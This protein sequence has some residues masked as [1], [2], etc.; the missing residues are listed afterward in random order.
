MERARGIRMI[1]YSIDKW[2]LGKFCG[3]WPK[4]S[5]FRILAKNQS[6]HGIGLVVRGHADPGGHEARA[7]LRSEPPSR[8]VWVE[9]KPA[10]LDP[11]T[12]SE[13]LQET[14]LSG[15]DSREIIEPDVFRHFFGR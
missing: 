9:T 8:P 13:P 12:P 1:E 11:L 5:A 15:L 10:G 7:R 6:Q 3:T 14:E 2:N 4:A